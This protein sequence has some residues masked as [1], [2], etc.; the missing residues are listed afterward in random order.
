[1]AV[2]RSRWTPSTILHQMTG[3]LR[4]GVAHLC[5]TNSVTSIRLRRNTIRPERYGTRPSSTKRTSTLRMSRLLHDY[6]TRLRSRPRSPPPLLVAAS[7]E[8]PAP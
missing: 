3:D 7:G 1:M 2:V 6:W 5:Y 8:A 4:P